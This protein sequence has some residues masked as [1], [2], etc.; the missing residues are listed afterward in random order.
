MATV[1]NGVFTQA[2]NAEVK[3]Y[4]V[5]LT[6]DNGDTFDTTTVVPNGNTM[7][8]IVSFGDGA[9]DIIVTNAAGTIT[10]TDS[11]GTFTGRQVCVRRL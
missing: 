3:E 11:V 5:D 9:S 4:V 8:M 7:S 6:M 10:V 1:N 2:L